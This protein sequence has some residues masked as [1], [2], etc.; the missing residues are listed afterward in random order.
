VS[1]TIAVRRVSVPRRIVIHGIDVDDVVRQ[2]N[3][4]LVRWGESVPKTAIDRFVEIASTV[5]DYEV[6]K[7]RS[8][9]NL[10][11][12][13]EV[14]RVNGKEWRVR[15]MMLFAL[16][17][18]ESRSWSE[19]LKKR[20]LMKDYVDLVLPR[21]VKSI[22]VT[23]KYQEVILNILTEVLDELEKLPQHKRWYYIMEKASL[24][25]TSKVGEIPCWSL[26][27]FMT[28]PGYTEFCMILCYAARGSYRYSQNIKKRIYTFL[29]TFHDNFEDWFIDEVRKHYV[30][31]KKAG[32]DIK[33]VRF[34]DSGNLFTISWF[35]TWLKKVGGEERAKEIIEK[36]K[37]VLGIDLEKLAKEDD[38]MYIRK[39]SNII[40]KLGEEGFRF[41]AYTRVWQD[42]DTFK[43]VEQYLLPLKNFVLYLS[44]D[45]VHEDTQAV[46]RDAF[47]IASKYNNVRLAFTGF[48]P[49]NMVKEY[50]RTVVVC[51]Q[52]L[53]ELMW[54][55]LTCEQCGIC[56]YGRADVVFLIH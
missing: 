13:P 12:I 28:C 46:L 32:K 6:E 50:K 1:T 54:S 17:S 39:L 19:K 35:I 38:G 8:V 47:D 2:L 27:A 7:I 9:M 11:N 44:L 5:P 56:P 43:Y 37:N 53:R 29:W 10:L 33:I 23:T 25:E 30:E 24:S 31:T 4:Y 3:E 15:D 14:V 20:V 18:Q 34:H 55:E 26:P 48:Y 51:P 21:F 22:P 36:F 41:Y 52:Q 45:K 49:A 16:L 40:R 42:R